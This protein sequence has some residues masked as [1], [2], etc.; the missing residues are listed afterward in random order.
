MILYINNHNYEIYKTDHVNSRD[1]CMG[2][3]NYQRSSFIDSDNDV[4]INMRSHY[5]IT[6]TISGT[7]HIC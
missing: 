4:I 3:Y 6:L 1:I 2:Y 5:R 7:F